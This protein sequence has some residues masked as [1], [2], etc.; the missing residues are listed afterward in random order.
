MSETK[1]Y[2]SR[3]CYYLRINS[4]EKD[5]IYFDDNLDVIMF[6]MRQITQAIKFYKWY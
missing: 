2:F 5:H 1:W 4:D 3:N 6:W